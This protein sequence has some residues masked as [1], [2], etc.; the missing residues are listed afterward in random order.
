M[1]YVYLYLTT[2]NNLMIK[3]LKN[4]I[5]GKKLFLTYFSEVY[6]RMKN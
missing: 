4:Q 3:F 2:Q 6:S 5:F 1:N